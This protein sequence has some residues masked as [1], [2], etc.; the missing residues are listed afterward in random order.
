MNTWF[1]NQY[2]LIVQDYRVLVLD[3]VLDLAPWSTCIN[4][5]TSSHTPPTARG[6]WCKQSYPECTYHHGSIH[7][8][9]M[10][11]VCRWFIQL[12]YTTLL[13]TLRSLKLILTSKFWWE[14]N[15]TIHTISGPFF[16][17]WM[18][19]MHDIILSCA[20]TPKHSPYL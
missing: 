8:R 16:V 2:V 20:H 6:N 12:C 14:N 10:Q 5:S 13:N 19:G 9:N 3:G 17:K 1:H 15:S 4:T 11:K 18:R 7:A